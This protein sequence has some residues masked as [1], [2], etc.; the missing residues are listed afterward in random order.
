MNFKRKIGLFFIDHGRQIVVIVAVITGI[1]LAIQGLD[2]Y[3]KIKNTNNNVTISEESKTT[4]PNIDIEKN[5]ENKKII[6]QFVNYCNDGN[7]EEAY[8]MISTNCKIEKFKDINT[9]KKNYIEKVFKI[10]QEIEI[11]RMQ[12]AS[13]E[14]TYTDDAL[15]SGGKGKNEKKDYVYIISENDGDKISINVKNSIL[16]VKKMGDNIKQIIWMSVKKYVFIAIAVVALGAF[17]GISILAVFNEAAGDDSEDD[18]GED[19]GSGDPSS[20]FYTR[21]KRTN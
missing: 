4:L 14:I 5:K 16:G 2:Y 12:D 15:L 17:L 19:T 21:I 8:Q 3:Y 1:I 10:K 6:N 18:S 20:S 7:I 9:F 11:S 13:Y